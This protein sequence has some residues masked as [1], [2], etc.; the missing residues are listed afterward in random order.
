[1]KRSITTLYALAVVCLLSSA[2]HRF[3]SAYV[4]IDKYAHDKLK[5]IGDLPTS[6]GP[7]SLIVYVWDNRT[8]QY[9]SRQ[10]YAKDGVTTLTGNSTYPII[11]G[12][13]WEEDGAELP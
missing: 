5:Y 2:T 4:R 10:V 3:E 8:A 11:I 9:V 1:M 13:S 12:R 7:Y 6:T